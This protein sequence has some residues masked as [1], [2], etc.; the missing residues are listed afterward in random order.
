[1]GAV[2]VHHARPRPVDSRYKIA[3]SRSLAL[4][5]FMLA[6]LLEVGG[7]ALIRRGLRGGGAGLV[8]L[9]FIVL[10]SYGI[11]V[12]LLDADFSRVLGA[13]VGVFALTSVLA[14]R[15]LFA[16]RVASSTWIGLAVILT[17]SLI[18]QF[19]RSR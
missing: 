3:V 11:A 1:L 15:L 7:D 8:A 5:A 18:I 6:A 12:N 13:Y 17:G 2:V 4:G 10:G 9:G 16:E 19:G 14:G